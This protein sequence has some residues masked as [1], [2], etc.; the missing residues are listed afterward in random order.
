MRDLRI[1][2][3]VVK[4]GSDVYESYCVHRGTKT[5]CYRLLGVTV[6]C[7]VKQR[8]PRTSDGFCGCL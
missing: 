8:I 5:I 6:L 3:R 1:W 2:K 7:L 4:I